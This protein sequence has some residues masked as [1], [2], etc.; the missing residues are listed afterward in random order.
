MKNQKEFTIYQVND[1]GDLLFYPFMALKIG[2]PTGIASVT[3]DEQPSLLRI[4]SAKGMCKAAA[5]I[6][7]S[8]PQN[9][10]N[11]VI[12]A[13]DIQMSHYMPYGKPCDKDVI[14]L[15]SMIIGGMAQKEL[16]SVKNGQIIRHFVNGH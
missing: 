11:S 4:L 16:K 3:V 9:F 2:F 7:R 14:I 8:Y 12:S 1:L 10:V 15:C 6:T 5:V 13:M